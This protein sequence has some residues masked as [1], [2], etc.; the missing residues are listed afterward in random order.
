[1]IINL[2]CLHFVVSCIIFCFILLT[3]KFVKTNPFEAFE[4][5]K[6]TIQEFRDN[7]NDKLADFFENLIDETLSG[8]LLPLLGLMF[9]VCFIPILNISLLINRIK[10]II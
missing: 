4:E 3:T 1:M 6:K 8:N 2:L 10:N 9:I 5:I 7:G